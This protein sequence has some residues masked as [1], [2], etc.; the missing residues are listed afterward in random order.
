MYMVDSIYLDTLGQTH[1]QNCSMENYEIKQ[2]KNIKHKY[3]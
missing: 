1:T 2:N 3:N